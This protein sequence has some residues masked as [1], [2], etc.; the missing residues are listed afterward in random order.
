METLPKPTMLSAID[1]SLS[2]AEENSLVVNHTTPGTLLLHG[3]TALDLI[4][5]MS[6]NDLEHLGKGKLTPTVLTNPHARIIDLI[7]VSRSERG[8]L[9]LTS[10]NKAQEVRSWLQSHIFFQDDVQFSEWY[11]IA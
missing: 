3:E 4:D 9:V 10:P 1:K 8:I 5:R 2:A 6:T 11:Q 7:W